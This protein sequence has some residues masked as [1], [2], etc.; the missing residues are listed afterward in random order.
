[1]ARI[2]IVEDEEPIIK[3]LTF[4]FRQEGYN[5]TV[6]QSGE[7]AIRIASE[8]KPE[9]ILLDIMLPGMDGYEVCRRIKNTPE[10]KDIYVIML[11]AKSQEADRERGFES[12]ADEYITKPFSPN[13]LMAK[14]KG[15]VR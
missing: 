4:L 10:L 5:F 11:S 8:R 7:E 3:S 14:V 9:L 15:I 1:M 12:G 2:L 6:A 13:Q